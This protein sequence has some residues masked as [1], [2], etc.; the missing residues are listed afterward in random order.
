VIAHRR[1]IEQLEAKNAPIGE[2]FYIWAMTDECLPMTEEQI[3]AA[4]EKVKAEGAPANAQFCLIRWSAPQ[5]RLAGH[6]HWPDPHR[7]GDKLAYWPK[8][9]YNPSENAAEG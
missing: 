7:A 9:V 6:P 3:D 5:S 2:Q 4:I 1:R 8:S